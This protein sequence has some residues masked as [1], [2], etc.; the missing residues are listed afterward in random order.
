MNKETFE[1]NIEKELTVTE[2]ALITT[3][4]Y[5]N[6]KYLKYA[7]RYLCEDY[8]YC[9]KFLI[10]YRHLLSLSHTPLDFEDVAIREISA[11][12]IKKLK[13]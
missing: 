8:N 3:N 11:M 12:K 2:L 7:Y 5:Y 9:Y 1:T 13:Q 4:I 10:K 6:P